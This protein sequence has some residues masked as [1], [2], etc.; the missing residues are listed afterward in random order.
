MI[1]FQFTNL[2][3]H[4]KNYLFLDHTP[5]FT[6]FKNASTFE[7]HNSE[8]GITAI[9]FLDEHLFRRTIALL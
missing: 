3:F 2:E 4:A 6:I 5:K 7:I 1:S 9:I 8:K